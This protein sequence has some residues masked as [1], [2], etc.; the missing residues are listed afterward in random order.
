L[1]TSIPFLRS[2]TDIAFCESF[3]RLTPCSVDGGPP[4]PAVAVAGAPMQ[5]TANAIAAVASFVFDLRIW[6]LIGAPARIL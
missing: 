5:T 3:V 1:S 2:I 6:V 4:L